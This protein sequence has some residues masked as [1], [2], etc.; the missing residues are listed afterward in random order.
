M[1]TGLNPC[2]V[3]RDD[4]NCDS[5]RPYT[6][7]SFL[8]VH[9]RTPGTLPASFYSATLLLKSFMI[10]ALADKVGRHLLRLE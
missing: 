9:H 10:F 5:V 8:D 4:I 2:I 1:D 3:Q 7:F 6:L